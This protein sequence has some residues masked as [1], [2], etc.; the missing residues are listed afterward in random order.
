MIRH[1]L[2]RRL[3]LSA[4]ALVAIFLGLSAALLD[5]AFYNAQLQAQE[6]NLN[7][8]QLLL[9][10]AAEWRRGSWTF[11]ELNEPQFNNPDSGVYAFVLG[12][13]GQL[14]WRSPSTDGRETPPFAQ[15]F[16]REALSN[17]PLG[18]VTFAPCRWQTLGYLCH[19]QVMAWGS[20][21]PESIFLLLQSDD[22]FNR[23]L[24]TWRINLVVLLGT[25]AAVLLLVLW[26]SLRWGLRP[27]K[28]LAG[29]LEQL[30]QGKLEQLNGRYPRELSSVT[31]NLNLLLDSERQRRDRMRN[32]LDRLAHTLKTPLM[33]IRNS[34]EQGDDFHRLVD[35]QAGRMLGAVE[36]ELARARLEGRKLDLLAVPLDVGPLL[37]RIA[38]AYSRLPRPGADRPVIIDLSEVDDSA[39]F[40]GEERDLQDLFG[41]V[42]ENAVRHCDQTVRVRAENVI[43]GGQ[44]W[45]ILEVA[46]DGPGV[47]PE[48][49]REILRRGARADSAGQGLG[50]SIAV[51]IASAYGGGVEVSAAD[52]GGALFSCSLPMSRAPG[53]QPA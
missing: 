45:L 30:E 20:T 32:T 43:E 38:G 10:R 21:G 39:V 16:V 2:F 5:R 12:R 34:D 17:L 3:M 24:Q 51:D 33:L 36:G 52:A 31:N 22:V 6:A 18:S 50:L 26:L 35:E 29:E 23:V 41:S 28:R 53:A 11:E 1:S 37:R 19:A 27:L 8:Q 7:L 47:P 46:D 42:L 48:L 25:T 44:R 13:D 15:R 49:R 14:Y 40:L 9:A 4:L